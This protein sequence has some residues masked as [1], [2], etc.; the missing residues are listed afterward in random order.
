M[1]CHTENS[2]TTVNLSHSEN[3][4]FRVKSVFMLYGEIVEIQWGLIGS[5]VMAKC[6]LMCMFLMNEV[7]KY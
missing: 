3:N 6:Q 1:I 7:P 5:Q 4:I 2:L